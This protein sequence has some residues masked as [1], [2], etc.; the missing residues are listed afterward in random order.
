[1]GQTGSSDGT[2]DEYLFFSTGDEIQSGEV[3]DSNSAYI[4]ETLEE[5]GLEV[6]RGFPGFHREL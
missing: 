6:T 1:M 5:A 3:L 2:D 4:A